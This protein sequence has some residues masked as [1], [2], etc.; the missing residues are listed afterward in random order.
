MQAGSRDDT[1]S[2]YD[3][4]S[5]AYDLIASSEHRYVEEGLRMLGVRLGE[6]V[7]EPGC[8][9]GRALARLAA[10]AGPRGE[11]TGLDLSGGMLEK[12]RRR[13]EKKGLAG[14]VE[15]VKGDAADMPCE[16]GSYD[17]VFISFT[18][19][20]FDA[21]EMPRVLGECRRVLRPGGRLAVVSLARR[22]APGVMERLYGR[23]H[24]R[25]PV[26]VDC[27]PI[28]VRDLLAQ[29]GFEASEIRERSMWGLPVDLILA[30]RD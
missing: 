29:A 8:G 16:D 6:R 9:T 17:A 11:V 10:G 26:W 20:L 18:L 25:F 5:R 4:I 24:A 23:A 28:P 19:E 3:R 22:G 21:E 2:F 7:L 12:A 15:L 13:L 14:R 27:R 30:A 1:R